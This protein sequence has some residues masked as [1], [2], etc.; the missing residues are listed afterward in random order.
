MRAKDLLL[1]DALSSAI[2]AEKKLEKQKRLIRGLMAIIITL[3]IV[4][5]VLAVGKISRRNSARR[6]TALKQ[7]AI[8]AWQR[9]RY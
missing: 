8:L 5:I 6:L 7:K 4:C 9:L 3:S 1:K 2:T